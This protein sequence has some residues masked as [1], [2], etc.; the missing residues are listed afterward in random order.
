MYAYASMHNERN[1]FIRHQWKY[2]AQWNRLV[3]LGQPY[4]RLT[5]DGT[6]RYGIGPVAYTP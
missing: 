2:L 1:A 4:A 6:L 3:T 5:R